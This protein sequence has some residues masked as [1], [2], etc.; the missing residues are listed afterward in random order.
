M[1]RDRTLSILRIAIAESSRFPELGIA[2]YA[3]GPQ[4]FR[5]RFRAWLDT[6]AA[7]G[8]VA[9]PD[10]LTATYQFMA[11]LRSDVF[12]R[13]GLGLPPPPGE[14]EID[15]TVTDAVATWLRAFAAPA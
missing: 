7:Q 11:L 2:F 5:D 1:L 4:K 10:T 14:A 15:A 12:L 6:L 13:A 9:T 3:N 8:L